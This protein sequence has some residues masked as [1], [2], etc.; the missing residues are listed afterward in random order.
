MTPLTLRRAAGL[1]LLAAALAAAGCGPRTATVSGKVT[2]QGKPVVVG[3]L[4]LVAA[5][6]SAHQTGLGP[7]GSFTLPSV[8]TGPARVGVSS[9][10]PPP[11]GKG[12]R[13]GDSRVKVPAPP[14]PGAW[15]RLP[16]KYADPTTSGVT[17]T[18]GGGP[19]DIDLK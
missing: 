4:T 12:S 6:G 15:V 8:P 17:V 16:D 3:T 11:A 9:P 13:S 7:D 14:P 10:E 19:A 18:V 1:G 2:Y 5:D